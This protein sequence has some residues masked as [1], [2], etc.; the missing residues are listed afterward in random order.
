VPDAEALDIVRTCRAGRRPAVAVY[1]GPP[2]VPNKD[3][4]IST[5]SKPRS[6][7]TK[8]PL[9]GATGGEV[10]HGAQHSSA[11]A[12]A[13]SEWRHRS[14]GC[15]NEIRTTGS[16]TWRRVLC[17][18]TCIVSRWSLLHSPRRPYAMLSATRCARSLLTVVGGCRRWSLDS[19][20]LYVWSGW[21]I[22]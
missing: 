20:A 11:A 2:R 1:A 16:V 21:L 6:M 19:A 8:T 13:P 9:G 17:L 12:A 10:R 14:C 4:R 3:H 5:V 22:G 18:R 7:R 15:V